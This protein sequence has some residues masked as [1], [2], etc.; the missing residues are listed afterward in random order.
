GGAGE[1]ICAALDDGQARA[2][3][4]AERALLAAL[5][6][7]CSGPIGAHATGQNPALRLIAVVFSPGGEE[8]VRR[9]GGRAGGGGESVGRGVGEG[10]GGELGARLLAAGAGELL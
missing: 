10:V 8:S 2:A 6:G 9:A 1:K 5:G 4:T 7:G 3:G